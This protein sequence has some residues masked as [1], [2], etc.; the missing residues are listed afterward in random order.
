LIP[1]FIRLYKHDPATMFDLNYYNLIIDMAKKLDEMTEASKTTGMCKMRNQKS[2][3][4]ETREA[5]RHAEYQKNLY[6]IEMWETLGLWDYQRWY[7]AYF[8]K[9]NRYEEKIDKRFRKE[10]LLET[11]QNYLNKK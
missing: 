8:N 7:L 6:D 3:S 10:Q 2:I 5:E 1:P 11:Q 9:S 4:R